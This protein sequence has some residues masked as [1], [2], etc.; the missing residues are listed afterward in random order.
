[1]S[2]ASCWLGEIGNSCKGRL[3][4]FC[5][6]FFNILPKTSLLR[7]VGATPLC[8]ADVRF[9]PLS[10]TGGA[11][12]LGAAPRAVSGASATRLSRGFSWFD[13]PSCL[14]THMPLNISSNSSSVY[15]VV[16]H[17]PH[18]PSNTHRTRIAAAPF[19]T[20]LFAKTRIGPET[21]LPKNSLVS[22]VYTPNNNR[23][24]LHLLYGHT[25]LLASSIEMNKLRE[26]FHLSSAA[27]FTGA[28]CAA[29][30]LFCVRPCL[31]NR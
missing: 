6:C 13:L 8:L 31:P 1:M 17:P 3:C 12:A 27:G 23:K 16:F 4:V 18:E 29:A 24:T 19:G 20:S 7:F 22:C 21:P 11:R 5:W 28:A 26:S 9:V 25:W 10:L 30:A 15:S 2:R 14:F